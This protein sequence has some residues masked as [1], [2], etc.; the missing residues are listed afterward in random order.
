MTNIYVIVVSTVSRAL[1]W[2][3]SFAKARRWSHMIRR[4]MN[5]KFSN[6]DMKMRMILFLTPNNQKRSSSIPFR[7]HSS[8]LHS[9][10]LHSNFPHS[11]FTSL[12]CRTDFFT[13]PKPLYMDRFVFLIL[14][15]TLNFAAAILGVVFQPLDFPSFLLAVF[16]INLLAY[17]AYYVIMK[18]IHGEVLLAHLMF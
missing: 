18:F 14:V 8:T 1:S 5:R 11:H 2:T 15:V 6:Q 17:F 9:V 4:S 10:Q 13:S 7:F 12:F 16:L 3:F